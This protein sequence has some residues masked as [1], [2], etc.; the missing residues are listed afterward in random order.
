MLDKTATTNFHSKP[1]PAKDPE[2][3]TTDEVRGGE[4]GH[5]VRYMLMFSLGAALIAMAI[6]WVFIV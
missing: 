3:L 5:G 6:A 1:M 2:S 4:T